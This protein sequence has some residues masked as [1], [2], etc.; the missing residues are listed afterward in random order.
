M[1]RVAR[2]RDRTQAGS[3]LAALVSA[4]GADG[5]VV[6]ALPRGGVPVA[7]EVARA[8]DAPLDVLI[9]RKL[10]TPGHAELA[11]GAVASGGVRFLDPR[12]R[13]SP[14]VAASIAEREAEQIAVLESRYRPPDF[15]SPPIEGRTVVLVDDGIATGATVIAAARSARLLGAAA[16]IVAVPIA[17]PDAVARLEREADRVDAVE[18]RAAFGA[19]SVLYDDFGEVPDDE[20]AALLAERR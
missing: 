2:F 4:R 20:V 7:V 18:V 8:L 11:F 15:V 14:A 9:V 10:R 17:P 6:L 16:V 12:A 13:M 5:A 1:R 19:V 3:E